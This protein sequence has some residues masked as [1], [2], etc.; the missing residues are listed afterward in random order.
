M[1]IKLITFTVNGPS[2]A[3]V[4]LKTEYTSGTDANIN[5]TT[6]PFCYPLKPHTEY[7]ILVLVCFKWTPKH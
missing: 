2:L 3:F 7:F 1:S 5:L 4:D 6:E